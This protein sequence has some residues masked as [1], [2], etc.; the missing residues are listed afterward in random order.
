MHFYS[1]FP[2]WGFQEPKSLPVLEKSPTSLLRREWLNKGLTPYPRQTANDCSRLQYLSTETEVRNVILWVV[3]AICIRNNILL[4]YTVFWLKIK[5]RDLGK[6]SKNATL[7]FPSADYILVSVPTTPMKLVSPTIKVKTKSPTIL[8]PLTPLTTPLFLKYF[9][10][11]LS[12]HS[13]L[14]I[15]HLPAWLSISFAHFASYV[16][17]LTLASHRDLSWPLISSSSMKS[18]WMSSQTTSLNYSLHA[19]SKNPISIW[20]FTCVLKLAALPTNWK[21][22]LVYPK[23]I[24]T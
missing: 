12:W 16:C 18:P 15:I 23:D 4:Y 6:K 20:F 7:T 21:L 14:L 10:H 19:I 11:L 17:P 1:P 24:S 8:L 9:G 13:M 5:M 22:L 3:L 2:V